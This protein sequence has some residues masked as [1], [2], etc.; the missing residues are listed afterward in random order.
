MKHT[1]SI[2]YFPKGLRYTAVLFIP[3]AGYLVFIGYPIWAVVVAL[4]TIFI[5]TAQYVTIIDSA[6]KYLIDAFAFYGI[7]IVTER[8][9]FAS[10]DKIVITKG[11]YSQSINT[12]A[13]SRQLDWTDYTGTLIYDDKGTLDLLTREDKK[14]LVIALKVYAGALGVA[15]EDHSIRSSSRS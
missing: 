15:I 7:N 2:Y 4:V 10:L 6:N 9:R 5:F 3:V 8:K 13:S 12:R 11:S 1:I 14:E